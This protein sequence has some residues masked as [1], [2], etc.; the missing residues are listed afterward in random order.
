[1]PITQ[2]IGV[3][4]GGRSQERP[5]SL[6]SGRFVIESLERLEY[7][8]IPIDPL[9]DNLL[10][11]LNNVSRVFLALHGWYGEDGKIQGYLETVG[12]PYTGSGVLASALAM[13]K[14]IFKQI[15]SAACIPTP[16]YYVFDHS[17]SNIERGVE[18]AVR[19]LN[20]PVIIK[21]W[22]G[23]GSLG[24]AIAQTCDEAIDATVEASREFG[25][26]FIEEYIQGDFLTVGMLGTYGSPKVLEVL[27]VITTTGFYDYNAKHTVGNAIYEVPAILPASIREGAIEFAS[28]IYRLLGCH[29]P[30]R[31]D[32]IL[33]KHAGI[34]I[35]EAN[36]LP[37]LSAQNSNLA[38]IAAAVNINYDQLIEEI[39]GSC[40][41]KPQYVP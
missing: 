21:P 32:M 19:S 23:G 35:L 6:L 10:L 22:S 1:M 7:S 33:G 9:T 5:G 11:L 24:V 31:V 20:L 14:V 36:T 8:V 13:N 34:Q 37:G 4:Y 18:T 28:R 40:Y 29:G 16:R 39:L 26:V 15:M 41:G 3:L 2:H 25:A 30:L 38:R 12:I 27:R 17:S